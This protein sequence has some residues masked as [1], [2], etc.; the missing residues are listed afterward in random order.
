M[1]E[2]ISVFRLGVLL[3]GAA[4]L[5]GVTSWSEDLARYQ[6][7]DIEVVAVILLPDHQ[8]G[9]IFSAIDLALFSKFI[10][11]RPAPNM[12]GNWGPEWD[13][14][15]IDALSHLIN[16]IQNEIDAIIPNHFEIGYKLAAALAVRNKPL[17]VIGVCHTDE[18]YYYHL[19]AKYRNIIS[20]T[21]AVCGESASKLKHIFG[22]CA[23][24]PYGVSSPTT[25]A[26]K[27]QSFG[28]IYV[29]RLVER[30]KRVSRLVDLARR[31]STIRGTEL[32]IVGGGE[33]Y[34]SLSKRFAE[35]GFDSSR[36]SYKF[37]G[38][39]SRDE[40]AMML[41]RAAVFALVSEAEGTP[42][43]MLEAM[44]ARVVPVVPRIAGIN[45]VIKDGWNGFLYDEGA[46]DDA[47]RIIRRL[48]YHPDL[49]QR[50]AD[51]ARETVLETY[52]VEQ[53]IGEFFSAVRTCRDCAFPT[54]EVALMAARDGR[55]MRWGSESTIT[56]D[57]SDFLK[58]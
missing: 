28:V 27:F 8:P 44:A 31:L 1:N 49:R 5:G 23:L 19:I 14:V 12:R 35:S 47:A 32:M 18:T 33:E 20:V 2:K 30:Q 45:D 29:G 36:F 16:Q 22:H 55:T 37:S 42:I 13:S 24:V 58:I 21:V 6:P 26:L 38:E 54:P 15:D 7:L 50:V 52:G 34:Q 11:L 51:A 56:R 10:L 41:P 17:H 4:P 3:D 46:I 25:D 53:R 40:V 9:K 43:S 39:L 48:R 57:S